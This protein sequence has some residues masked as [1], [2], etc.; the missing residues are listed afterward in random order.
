MGDIAKGVLGGAW[1]L[2]VGWILPTALNLSVFFFTVA[3]SLHHIDL[4]QRLWPSSKVDTALLLLTVSLLLGLVVS[5]VQTLLYRLLEGYVLWPAAAYD[6][7]CRR[8][9][10]TKRDLGDR[11]ALL[12]LEGRERAG[13][14]SPEA[15]RQ[16]ADLRANPRIGRAARRDRL[17]TA[18]QR[19]LLQERLR[20]YPIADDQVAPTRLGNAIRRLEEYGYDRFR[21]D[22]QVLWGELTGTAPEQVRRQ[23]EL[24][25]VS[26]DFFIALLYGHAAVAAAAL[27]ALASG[28]ADRPVLLTTAAVLVALIPLWYRSAVTATD[29]W[30]AAVRALVNVGRK[31]LAESLGLALPSELAAERTMWTLVCLLSRAPYHERAAALDPYRADPQPPL[32]RPP[33]PPP[34]PPPPGS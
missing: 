17:R 25:R 27:A 24:A 26:V 13:G 7:R 22:T 2:L 33:V 21:L 34:T 12:R 18:A 9:R 15:T 3:P 8:H 32:V 5:A 1:T 14:L 30:A 20:R 23:E 11:L 29:E 6:A 31:P 16:L 19:A 4:A 28:D 10:Q